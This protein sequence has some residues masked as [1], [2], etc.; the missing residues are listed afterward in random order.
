[1]NILYV[2]EKS[3]KNKE[4]TGGGGGKGLGCTIE[5]GMEGGGTLL[6]F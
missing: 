4:R 3:V 6:K 1:M 2:V 5:G